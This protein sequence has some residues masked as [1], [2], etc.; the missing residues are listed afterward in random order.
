LRDDF[1]LRFLMGEKQQLPGNYRGSQP[2]DSAIL[3]HQSRGG[4]FCEELALATL[5]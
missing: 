1:T 3:K 2:E 5:F 4:F